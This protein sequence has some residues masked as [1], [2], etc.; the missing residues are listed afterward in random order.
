MA[1]FIMM[2]GSVMYFHSF[3]G[4]S[5]IMFLGLFLVILTMI[6]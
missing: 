2:N 4:G 6:V 1:A 3:K 5:N